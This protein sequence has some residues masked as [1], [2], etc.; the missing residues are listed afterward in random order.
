MKP[1]QRKITGSM[2]IV[3]IVATSIFI[4]LLSGAISLGLLQGKL[5]KIKVAQAQA[6]HIAEA[7]INYYKWVLYHAENDYCNKEECILGPNYGPYGPYDY[8]D[9]FGYVNGQYEL[10]ITPPADSSDIITIKSVGWV[11]EYPNV[12]RTIEVELG[13]LSLAS[14]LLL[15]NEDI[16]ISK[17]TETSGVI[18]SNGGV[19]FDGL[20]NINSPVNSALIEYDDPSHDGDNEFGVHTHKIPVDP[21]PPAFIPIRDDVFLGGRFFPVSAIN[22]GSLEGYVAE[23]YSMATTDEDE[24]G[25]EDGLVLEG[26]GAYGYYIKFMPSANPKMKIYRVTSI[27]EPCKMCLI[28]GVCIRWKKGVCIEYAPCISWSESTPTYGVGS[29]GNVPG[30]LANISSNNSQWDVPESGIIFVKDNVWIDAAPH[31]NR[32]Q[33]TVLA[34]NDLINPNII[35]NSSIAYK[36]TDSSS[37]IG[38]IAQNDILL[39]LG[40]NNNLEI[41]AAMIAINGKIGRVDYPNYCT[42]NIKNSLKIFGSMVVNSGY[43]F[44]Y[45]NDSGVLTS[46]YQSIDLTYDAGLKLIPPPH[47]PLTGEYSFLSWR[48]N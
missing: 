13:K 12:K 2:L 10:Y 45:Y 20:A 38:L 31:T 21:S 39:G 28:Q 37:V 11:N 30:N 42:G 24:D 48:E 23:M 22:I 4:M 32:T 43:G 25:I 16:L 17:N 36:N 19:R 26:S 29:T 5:N 18:H 33:V 6:L 8:S 35:I 47:F 14:H 44:S 3:V 46:G 27:T 7:G 15:S 34:F 9:Q 1:F 41:D 40:S